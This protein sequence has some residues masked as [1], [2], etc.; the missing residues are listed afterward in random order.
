MAPEHLFAVQGRLKEIDSYAD[1][2]FKSV[3]WFSDPQSI[4]CLGLQAPSGA[5]DVITSFHE[6]LIKAC[7]CA[8]PRD[9]DVQVPRYCLRRASR[10][11]SR[12]DQVVTKDYQVGLIRN[13]RIMLSKLSDSSAVLKADSRHIYRIRAQFSNPD[14]ITSRRLRVHMVAYCY[15]IFR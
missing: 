3:L 2:C 10:G 8:G 12:I 11:D 5:C 15:S 6:S 7:D 14:Q 4:H 13:R 1:S 9:H